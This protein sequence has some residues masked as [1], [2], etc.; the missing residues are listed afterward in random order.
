MSHPLPIRSLLASALFAA[1]LCAALLLPVPAGAVDL[2]AGQTAPSFTL[3][4][5]DGKSVSLETFRGRTV[6]IAFFS[7]WCSRCEEE[8]SFL[9]DT[10][11]KRA[12]VSVILVNQ[13]GEDKVMKERIRGYRDR[14]AIDFP[15]V[16]DEGLTLWERYGI[17]ALP[18]SVV[19]GADGRVVF[20]E[21]NFYWASPEKLIDAVGKVEKEPAV[22]QGAPTG[23]LSAG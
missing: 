12:D 9:R 2:V 10:F 17:N 7:T 11:G 8:I 18:T 21:A 5:L 19:V 16:L 13:D 1:A 6:L 14:L 23:V 20:V 22:V 3:K 4:D 15:M